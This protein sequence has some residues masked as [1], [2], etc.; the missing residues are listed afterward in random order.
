[1]IT[2]NKD[3][4]ELLECITLNEDEIK[5]YES[6]A[7]SYAMVRFNGRYLICL[8]TLRTQWEVPA[9][10]REEGESPKECAIRELFEETTQVVRDMEFKGLLKVRKPNGVIKYNP[11]YFAD[12]DYIVPFKENNETDKILYWNLTDDI[13]YVDEVDKAALTWCKSLN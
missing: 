11:V 12:L 13:G 4:Y 5:N 8:N 2:T 7:G 6:L 3:G 1:V 9:G 10:V